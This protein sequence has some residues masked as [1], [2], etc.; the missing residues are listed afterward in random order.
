MPSNEFLAMK[1]NF[2]EGT[3]VRIVAEKPEDAHTGQPGWNSSKTKLLNEE[4]VVVGH[5]DL[6][7]RSC[8]SVSFISGEL[9][10]YLPAW[11]IK[12]KVELENCICSI[13]TLM[14]AGCQCGFFQKE[15]AMKNVN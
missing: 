15:M 1:Q 3:R 10:R 11:V 5:D 9:W 7:K 13:F 14:S 4:G 6:G 2:P 12:V 8:M